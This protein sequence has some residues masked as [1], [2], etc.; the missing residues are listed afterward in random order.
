MGVVLMMTVVAE[1]SVPPVLMSRA[2]GRLL[3]PHVEHRVLF[4]PGAY[5]LKG[6][7]RTDRGKEPG[8]RFPALGTVGRLRCPGCAAVQVKHTACFTEKRVNGHGRSPF[9]AKSR[10]SPLVS[11]YA[12]RW[13]N[14]HGF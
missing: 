9:L 10:C 11:P 7:S 8:R 3:F 12:E 2:A 4:A 14:K 6:G 1:M 5:R 13:G